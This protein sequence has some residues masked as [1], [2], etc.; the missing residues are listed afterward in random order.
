MHRLNQKLGGPDRATARAAAA[1]DPSS[2]IGNGGSRKTDSIGSVDSSDADAEEEEE[3]DGNEGWGIG[4]GS[5][6]K[7]GSSKGSR[8]Y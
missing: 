5:W 7:G 3:E 2:S 8:A 1:L 6:G 4:I